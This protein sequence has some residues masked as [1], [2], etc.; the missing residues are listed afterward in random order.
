M[1]G[2][3]STE[4]QTSSLR[5]GAVVL[6]AGFSRRFGSTKLRAPLSNGHTVFEQTL[7]R[8]AAATSNIIV[9]TRD[10]L[11]D[12]QHSIVGLHGNTVQIVVCAEAS[13]GMGHTLACGIEQIND[14]D[15]CLICLGDMP[16]IKT[17]TYAQLL[18]ALTQDTIVVPTYEG[19]NGHPVGFGQN[20]FQPMRELNGDTGAKRVVE[21]HSEKVT[22]LP[23][24]DP[25]ILQDID[26]PE[27]LKRLESHR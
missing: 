6:A 9:V 10:G 17:S 14:W 12:I 23:L 3:T 2:A 7:S 13:Q 25:A 16:F 19:K 24:E 22:Y 26:T 20:F 15:A 18:A 4:L 1:T 5:T 21:A 11:D 27:D 8:L